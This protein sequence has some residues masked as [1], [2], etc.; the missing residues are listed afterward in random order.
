[1]SGFNRTKRMVK[2]NPALFEMAQKL[3]NAFS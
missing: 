1:M 2:H 3:R